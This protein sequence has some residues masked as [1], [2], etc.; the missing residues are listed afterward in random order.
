MFK[1]EKNQG[2]VPKIGDLVEI[3]HTN[4]DMD[5]L[6]GKLGGWGTPDNLI[7][8]V[9]LDNPYRYGI[10]VDPVLVVSM[11]VVCLRSNQFLL[12]GGD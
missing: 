2:R 1:Y 11:P 3:C 4:S 7:G 5:G 12:K 6:C 9:I 8:L 10:G